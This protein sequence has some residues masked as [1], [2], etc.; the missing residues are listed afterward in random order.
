MKWNIWQPI[1]CM[2]YVPFPPIPIIEVRSVLFFTF[3]AWIFQSPGCLI[4]NTWGQGVSEDITGNCPVVNLSPLQHG[5]FHGTLI[6]Y[7]WQGH[8]KIHFSLICIFFYTL[9]SYMIQVLLAENF[10]CMKMGNIYVLNAW[11]EVN[12]SWVSYPVLA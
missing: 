7:H 10:K 5:P 8:C 9:L 3:L 2:F 12:C 1:K 6:S 4:N 11:V